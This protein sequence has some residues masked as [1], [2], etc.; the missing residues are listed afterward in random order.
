M[1]RQPRLDASEVLHRVRV[2]E[3]ER[4]VLLRDDT[5]HADCVARLAER[6]C[7]TAYA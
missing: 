1:P 4:R 5:D 3:L 6:G 7:L 2:R